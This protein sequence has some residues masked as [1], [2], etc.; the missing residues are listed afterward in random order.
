MS[1][2]IIIDD[3]R[4]EHILLSKIVQKIDPSIEIRSFIYAEEALAFLRSPNRQ[5][6]R[7][8]FVDINMPRMNGFEFAQRYRDLYNELRDGAS[9]WMMSNSIDPR[10]RER[11]EANPA[12][13]GYLEKAAT[14]SAFAD[15]VRSTFSSDREELRGAMQQAPGETRIG[16]SRSSG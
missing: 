8:I 12:I 15:I 9:L 3:D 4:L 7:L 5:N 14:Q 11:A 13:T 6:P 10:D 1:D 16:R 2:L